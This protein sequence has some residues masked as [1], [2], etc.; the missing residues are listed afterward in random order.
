MPG[1]EFY[2]QSSF[3]DWS[4]GQFSSKESHNTSINQQKKLANS[5]KTHAYGDKNKDPISSRRKK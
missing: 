4:V 2:T 3:V 1:L 5:L